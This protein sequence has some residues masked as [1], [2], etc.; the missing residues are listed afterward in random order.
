[1]FQIEAHQA[2][3]LL[4]TRSI[5]FKKCHG[6]VCPDK[7]L[8]RHALNLLKIKKYTGNEAWF[9]TWVDSEER[10]KHFDTITLID[11][12]ITPKEDPCHE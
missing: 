3:E 5:T 9:D 8:D 10:Q 11:H 6:Y 1:M 4:K 2:Q 7:L 12:D